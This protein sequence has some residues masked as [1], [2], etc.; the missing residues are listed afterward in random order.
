RKLPLLM[1]VAALAGAFAIVGLAQSG[2]QAVSGFNT[3]LNNNQSSAVSN[4]F[5]ANDVF[6]ADEG[7]F[8]EEE[9]I[10][11][12]LG[13]VYNARSCVDCHAQPN[14]G[15]TSQVTELRVGH[16]AIGSVVNPTS[17]IKDGATSIPGRALGRARRIYCEA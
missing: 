2:T 10:G 8:M 1:C 13:P 17:T 14:V 7:V 4:G 15:G 6:A 16:P 5:T 12:G 9:D 11:D 3:P